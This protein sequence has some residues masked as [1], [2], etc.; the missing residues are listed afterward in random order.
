M[1]ERMTENEARKAM[2]PFEPPLIGILRAEAACHYSRLKNF[3]GRVKIFG[4][5]A[6]L[7]WFKPEGNGAIERCAP[8]KFFYFPHNRF[9]GEPISAT[10][11]KKLKKHSVLKPYAGKEVKIIGIISRR[12]IF[13]MFSVTDSDLEMLGPEEWFKVV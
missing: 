2:V 10:L 12:P 4:C 6:H 13:Y 9:P 7:L 5:T 3:V 11:T 8:L 1:T